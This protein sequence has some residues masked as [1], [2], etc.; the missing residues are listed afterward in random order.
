MSTHETNQTE[1]F[2]DGGPLRF[3]RRLSDRWSIDGVATAFELAGE[4]FGRTHTLRMLDYST[5]GIGAICE[6]VISPGTSVS[7]GFQSP[8]YPA[9][10]GMIIRCLPCGEGYRMAVIFEQRMAA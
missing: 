7:I 2:D 3:E 9:R 10:R 6:T 8:G 1:T 4:G 5:E